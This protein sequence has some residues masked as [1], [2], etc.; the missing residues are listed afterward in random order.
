M[1]SEASDRKRERYAT[2]PE[3]RERCK[4]AARKHGKKRYA[5]D[6]E[7]RELKKSAP[8]RKPKVSWK[9]RYATDPEFREKQKARSRKAYNRAFHRLKTYGLTQDQFDAMFTDQ[10]GCCA[11]CGD[12]LKDAGKSTHVDHDH[13]TGKV[14][15]LLCGYCNPALGLLKEDPERIRALAAYVERHLGGGDAT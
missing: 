10:D 12:K 8:Y 6:A 2:D 13:K 4:A 7:Y 3:F 1:A 5:E 11:S 9:E 15:A 14:R